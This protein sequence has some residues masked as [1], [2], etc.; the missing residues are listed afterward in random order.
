MRLLKKQIINNK[1]DAVCQRLHTIKQH[2]KAVKSYVNVKLDEKPML[3]FSLAGC[4]C[5][6]AVAVTIP[7]IPSSSTRNNFV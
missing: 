4:I 7:L 6:I 3:K 5:G 1:K 2:S